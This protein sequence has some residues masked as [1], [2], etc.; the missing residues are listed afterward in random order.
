MKN[1]PL[2]QNL[3]RQ[4]K[5]FADIKGVS[6]F[7]YFSGVCNLGGNNPDQSLRNK[8]IDDNK[9]L[10]SE[11]LEC[12][13]TE[14]GSQ[15][16]TKLNLS[17]N[18]LV[19]EVLESFDRVSNISKETKNALN[20]DGEIDCREAKAVQKTVVHALAIL[21]ELYINLDQAIADG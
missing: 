9:K 20:G 17:E 4:M 12:I 8:F 16:A 11:Q 18:D 14:L 21:N 19:R 7:Q 3:L 10:T 2:H 15:Q 5:V 1:K 6:H 13:V